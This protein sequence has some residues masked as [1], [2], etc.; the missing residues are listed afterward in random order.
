M[1]PLFFKTFSGTQISSQFLILP[2]K[3][4]HN[5][6]PTYFSLCTFIFWGR[7]QETNT[8]DDA[9][10]ICDSTLSFLPPPWFTLSAPGFI[11]STWYLFIKLATSYLPC[12]QHQIT[13]GRKV[14]EIN[15]CAYRIKHW[16]PLPLPQKMM[17]EV[18]FSLK[19]SYKCKSSQKHTK[20]RFH[21]F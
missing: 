7:G 8:Y 15:N 9:A 21:F 12:G 17:T 19:S 13:G 1:T 6:A 20:E 11:T 3:A 10:L 2:F 14:L 18:I 16:S 5:L 4:L